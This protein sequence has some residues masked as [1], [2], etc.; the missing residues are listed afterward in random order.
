MASKRAM[1]SV[2]K[3]SPRYRHGGD[4]LGEFAVP[5]L[6]FEDVADR[7]EGFMGDVAVDPLEVALTRQLTKHLQNFLPKTPKDLEAGQR[8][9]EGI[10]ADALGE[11][12]RGSEPPVRG[13]GRAPRGQGRRSGSRVKPHENQFGRVAERERAG[14]VR[15]ERGFW[16][17][18][19][20][21][22]SWKS[23]LPGG[24]EFRA[25]NEGFMEGL[26]GL[27]SGTRLAGHH[28]AGLLPGV[29]GPSQRPAMPVPE[30]MMARDRR[31]AALM[32]LLA[33][34]GAQGQRGTIGIRGRRG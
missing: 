11:I 24:S 13:S 16:G 2:D 20:D 6:P 32:A 33:Q 23:I 27:G 18:V 31:R 28:I 15:D 21:A 30:G 34:R 14:R 3:R 22:D 4:P 26:R 17:T 29:S 12:A 19:K 5:D 25:S 7:S 9:A 10:V 1:G 8:I